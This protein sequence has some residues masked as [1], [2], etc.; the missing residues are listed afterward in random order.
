MNTNF[1]D[2]KNTPTLKLSNT[3][4]LIFSIQKILTKDTHRTIINIK[5]QRDY[6]TQREKERERGGERKFKRYGGY[7]FSYLAIA[8]YLKWEFFISII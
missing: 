8:N 4:L 5:M 2:N 6:V 3:T 7:I 1:S